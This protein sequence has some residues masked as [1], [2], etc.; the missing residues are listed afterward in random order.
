MVH[1]DFIDLSNNA[2]IE[3]PKIPKIFYEKIS[4]KIAER[5]TFLDEGFILEDSE[6]NTFKRQSNNG[7]RKTK[8]PNFDWIVRI[9]SNYSKPIRWTITKTINNETKKDKICQIDKK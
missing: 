3:L 9:T 4:L 1:I 7:I 6:H 5:V 2:I 8:L